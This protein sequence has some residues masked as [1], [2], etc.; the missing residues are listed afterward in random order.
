RALNQRDA[1]ATEFASTFSRDLNAAVAGATES[2]AA[3]KEQVQLARAEATRTAALLSAGSSS[4]A[5]LDT[6]NATLADL[7]RQAAD[8]QAI[9][10]RAHTRLKAADR[11]VFLLEDGT[12]GNTAFQNLADARLR[13]V[14]A[15][16]TLTQLKVEQEAAE[17]V[18]AKTR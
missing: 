15:R 3:L 17:H 5:A 7:R 18:L 8:A 12:D 2:L 10:D 9:L 14:Q 16:E 13:L 4:Q 11:G 6:A 1:H